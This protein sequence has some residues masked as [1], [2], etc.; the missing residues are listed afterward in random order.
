MNKIIIVDNIEENFKET[1]YYNG[2]KVRTW[3]DS[4]NDKELEILRPFLK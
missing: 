3:V 2:I 4:M 1:S